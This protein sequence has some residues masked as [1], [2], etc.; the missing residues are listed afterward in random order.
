MLRLTRSAARAGLA[1]VL[2]T[3]L[4]LT[5]ERRALAGT[6]A[7]VGAGTILALA[8][9]APILIVLSTRFPTRAASRVHYNLRIILGLGAAAVAAFANQSLYPRLYQ[10]AHLALATVVLFACV[11]AAD[12]MLDAFANASAVHL[13]GVFGLGA[14]SFFSLGA[15]PAAQALRR[16]PETTRALHENSELLR[17]V[18]R[19]AAIAHLP[20]RSPIVTVED[21][22]ARAIPSAPPTAPRWSVLLITVD[23]LRADHVGAYGYARSTTPRLD[24]LAREGT[25]F[26][27]AY[28]SAPQTPYAL[29]SIMT[30]V[31][32][33]AIRHDPPTWAAQFASYGY[34]TAAF[35]PEAIF[36]TDR[37]RFG[38]FAARHF[39]FEEASVEYAAAEAL[40]LRVSGF[41]N[42][43]PDERR[44][45]AW[46]H[47]FEPHEP[48]EPHPD[49]PFGASD[50]DRY[51]AEIAVT[52]RAIGSLVDRV[53]A[54]RPETLVI[55]TADHGEA[56]GEHASRYHGT[57]LYEEQI[58]VPLVLYGPG[59]IEKQVVTR[60]VQTI[61]LLPTIARMVDVP[62][63]GPLRGAD[64]F[65][66]TEGVAFSSLN[67]LSSLAVGDQ[68]LICQTAISTCALFDL[69][70]DPGQHSPLV[71][72]PRVELLRARLEAASAG[73]A[74]IAPR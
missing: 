10:S 68:R 8:L 17:P 34:A 5:E 19:L 32:I 62:I 64:L 61:D 53:R 30:G 39:E 35:Y 6:P 37:E 69:D 14:L 25:M 4:V 33:R 46:A 73:N 3:G 20:P 15:A 29:A 49:F 36:F 56:F 1:S 23:A 71:S 9:S 57:T 59:A 28:T 40:A 52:D 70:S 60:A 63:A 7:L 43:L 51:D 58:R 47:F 65:A 50:I 42:R 22:L 26:T 55:V 45:F 72:G 18:V 16:S 12:G 24:A 54:R 11:V 38:G 2:A 66:A 67:E 27:H 13:G 48:Y 21:P 74:A 44:F 31:H 41:V